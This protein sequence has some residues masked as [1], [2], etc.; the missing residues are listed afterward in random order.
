MENHVKEIEHISYQKS[1]CNIARS[2]LQQKKHSIQTAKINS[3]RTAPHDVRA[4]L[5]NSHAPPFPQA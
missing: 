2:A 1:Y 3:G 5:Q 4:A